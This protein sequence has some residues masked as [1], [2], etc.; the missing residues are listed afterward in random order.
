ML[1]LTCCREFLSE[2]QRIAF[3]LCYRRVCLCVCVCVCVCVAVCVCRVCGRQENGLR[4]RR[5]FLTDY[6]E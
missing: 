2:I 6:A 1:L 5:R 3:A 4:S